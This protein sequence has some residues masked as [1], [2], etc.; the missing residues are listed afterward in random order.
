MAIPSYADTISDSE[1]KEAY[2][3]AKELMEGQK[4]SHTIVNICSE[5]NVIPIDYILLFEAK[6]FYNADQMD[7]ISKAYERAK[8][9][10]LATRKFT[11][12][13]Y[14]KDLLEVLVNANEALATMST[15]ARGRKTAM[16]QKINDLANN[17][18]ICPMFIG[19]VGDNINRLP[20]SYEGLRR[21][22]SVLSDIYFTMFNMAG[23]VAEP[24]GH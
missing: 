1:Y 21:R 13:G 2:T 9:V 23:I 19:S 18:L 17:N 16:L 5:C 12:E 8:K 6:G 7:R 3:R 15:T 22:F 24:N 14:R 4:R 11:E 10:K 20:F